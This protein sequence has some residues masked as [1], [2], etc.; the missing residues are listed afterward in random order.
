MRFLLRVIPVWSP[1]CDPADDGG[2]C[3]ERIDRAP[4]FRG[5]DGPLLR[6]QGYQRIDAH[7]AAC[8]KIARDGRYNRNQ[9]RRSE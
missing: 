4:L 6:A 5:L 1:F 8:R 9:H 7:R 2:F 3:K